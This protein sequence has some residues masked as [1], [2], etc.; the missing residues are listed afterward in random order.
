MKKPNLF[1]IGAP[2][3][4][5]TALAKY[6]SFHTDVFMSS[7]KEPRYFAD[8]YKSIRNINS[9]QDYSK[10]FANSSGQTIIGEAS[11]LYLRSK[12]AINN[13]YNYNS[14][15]KIIIMLRNYV[16]YLYSFHH[17]L[18][19]D[20]HENIRDFEL[21]WSAISD[22]KKGYRIPNYC[23]DNRLLYY[24]EIGKLGEQLKRVFEV[25]PRDQVMIIEFE[26]F[27]KNTNHVYKDVL[28]FLNLNQDHRNEFPKINAAKEHKILW[29]GQS[30]KYFF[31]RFRP[32]FTLLKKMIGCNNTGLFEKLL[33]LNRRKISRK[34]LSEEFINEI[35]T[36]FS[37][38][39][40]KLKDESKMDLSNW[41]R[42]I[43]SAKT[44]GFN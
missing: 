2:K 34:P 24:D 35:D 5:T 30:M 12:T 1:I 21:A 11:P 33:K 6:L 19:H 7:P 44:K 42:K 14:S 40:K 13:I 23:K 16:D 27:I 18:L 26:N 3:C 8:D 29:F 17:Q 41:F 10:L 43:P 31:R 32:G 4:G 39:F 37:N 15:A 20:S 9:F 28:K 36:F 22:R 25:F 38:D